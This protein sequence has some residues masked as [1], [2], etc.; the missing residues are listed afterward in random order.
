MILDYYSGQNLYSDGDIEDEILSIYRENKSI[1]E[2]I[3]N[4]DRWAILYHLTSIR[5]NLLEWYSFDAGSSLLEIGGGCGALTGLFTEKCSEVTT[6]ELSKRRADVIN[7]RHRDSN[8]L[9]I[10]VG[11][12]NEIPF[13]KKFDYITLIGVLEYAGAFTEGANPYLAFL[14]Q[15]KKLLNPNGRLLIAIE[16]RFGL[17]YFAGAVEDHTG[18]HF[19]GIQGYVNNHKFRTFGKY[20]LEKMVEHAGYGEIDFYYPFPDYKLPHLIYSDHHLPE[21]NE[22]FSDSQ[23]YDNDRLMLFREFNAFQGIIDNG[24][25]PFFANSFLLNIKAE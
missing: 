5:R 9:D 21:R 6:V 25:F 17:K 19:D 22:L 2:I 20:E 14:K 10:I 7:H 18:I 13:D 15:I 4:D 1:D 24:Q 11:N 16:N 23:N 3:A 8:N 12:L